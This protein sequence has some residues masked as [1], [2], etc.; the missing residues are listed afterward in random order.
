MC[1]KPVRRGGA[2]T[3]QERKHET[4]LGYTVTPPQPPSQILLTSV[5]YRAS[6][7][8]KHRGAPETLLLSYNVATPHLPIPLFKTL[9]L[10][11]HVPN[12]LRG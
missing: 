9:G 8:N 5:I 10:I 7:K 11:L 2:G 4:Y 12:L 6:S 1:V 3:M